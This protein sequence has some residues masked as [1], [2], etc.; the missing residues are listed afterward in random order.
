MVQ[1]GFVFKFAGTSWAPELICLSSTTDVERQLQFQGWQQRTLCW[2]DLSRN[3]GPPAETKSWVGTTLHFH[4]KSE[5][6]VGLKVLC[7]FRL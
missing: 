7:C 1:C 2:K 5:H 4:R 3:E 6:L